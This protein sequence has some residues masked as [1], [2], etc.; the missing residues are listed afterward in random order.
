M[1]ERTLREFLDLEGRTN[2]EAEYRLFLARMRERGERGGINPSLAPEVLDRIGQFAVGYSTFENLSAPRPLSDTRRYVEDV[3]VLFDIIWREEELLFLAPT[4][5]LIMYTL[6]REWNDENTDLEFYGTNDSGD[7]A[8]LRFWVYR[9]KSDLLDSNSE[10]MR[11]GFGEYLVERLPPLLRQYEVIGE[12]PQT[13]S[14]VS[15]TRGVMSTL[16]SLVKPKERFSYF[17]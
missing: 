12:L 15:P 4:L 5:A 13:R 9:L 8:N 14:N 16:K 11:A 1:D 6:F 7:Y 17:T 3:I 2:S 10:L